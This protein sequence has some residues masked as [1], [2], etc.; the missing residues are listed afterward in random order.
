MNTTLAWI[1][2][3]LIAIL[4][5]VG[6]FLAAGAKDGGIYLFGLLL[7]LFAVLF[8]FGLIKRGTG[9]PR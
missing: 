1:V 5:L 9:G 8:D 6:L 7:F 3:G 2:G 4:G